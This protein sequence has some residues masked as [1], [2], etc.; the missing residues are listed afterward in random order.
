MVLFFW[1][2]QTI[3]PKCLF[4]HTFSRDLSLFSVRKEQRQFKQQKSPLCFEVIPFD[5]ADDL[6]LQDNANLFY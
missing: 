3:P 2:G 1:V 6:L 4:L 5:N